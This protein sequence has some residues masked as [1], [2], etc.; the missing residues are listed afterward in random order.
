MANK[1]TKIVNYLDEYSGIN[2]KDRAKKI[3]EGW[4]LVDINLSQKTVY[5]N[6]VLVNYF[7]GNL[8]Y[9]RKI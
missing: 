3:S 8:V 2:F 6:G 4:E 5:N 1:K 9:K 7:T